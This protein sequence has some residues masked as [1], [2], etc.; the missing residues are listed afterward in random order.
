MSHQD[1]KFPFKEEVCNRF[2]K[3]LNIKRNKEIDEAIEELT[4]DTYFEIR[5]LI[6]QLLTEV[7]R[8]VTFDKYDGYL[9]GKE[10][11]EEQKESIKEVKEDLKEFIRESVEYT[12]R[13][14]LKKQKMGIDKLSISLKPYMKNDETD[15][16]ESGE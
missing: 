9:D 13:T 3:W 14:M 5:K 7:E 15:M 12:W 16:D 10:L 8:L 1:N 6:C 4:G 2:C 11:T